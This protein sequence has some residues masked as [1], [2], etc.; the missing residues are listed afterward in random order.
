MKEK[1]VTKKI[2]LRMHEIMRQQNEAKL[3]YLVV[4]IANGDTYK[5]YVEDTKAES[6][7]LKPEDHCAGPFNDVA[8]AR[9]WI[10]VNSQQ[11]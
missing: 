7:S 4:G 8:E 10:T 5:Y 11:E 1:A 6:K 9:N 3:Q 2:M